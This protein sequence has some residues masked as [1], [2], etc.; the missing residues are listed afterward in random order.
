MRSEGLSNTRAARPKPT[1]PAEVVRAK[2]E[3]LVHFEAGP[4]LVV[5]VALPEGLLRGVAVENVRRH[6]P[7][8]RREALFANMTSGH[9]HYTVPADPV[10]KSLYCP[11]PINIKKM[12]SVSST[13]RP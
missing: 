7:M 1:I 5:L 13:S 3:R 9:R 2:T 6:P 10:R 11:G 4:R 12:S 8:R